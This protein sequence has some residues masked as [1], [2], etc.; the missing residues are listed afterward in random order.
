MVTE[1]QSGIIK[2]NIVS[3]RC[4]DAT[5]RVSLLLSLPVPMVKNY[6]ERFTRKEVTQY[7]FPSGS[8]SF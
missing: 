2:I 5:G 3:Q 4:R 8:L 7:G 1:R 6:E